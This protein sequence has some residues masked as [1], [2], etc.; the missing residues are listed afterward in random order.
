[1]LDA[2]AGVTPSRSASALVVTG[3]V[4]A[5]LERVDRLGVVLDR[6]GG[7]RVLGA[8]GCHQTLTSRLVA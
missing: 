2:E 1:M 8:R 4:A 7:P 5:L 3:A 6:L